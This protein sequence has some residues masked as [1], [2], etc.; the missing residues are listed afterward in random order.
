MLSAFNLLTGAFLC[1]WSVWAKSCLEPLLVNLNSLHII[2]S[3]KKINQKKY[4]NNDH[5]ILT[6]YRTCLP[7]YR[8]LFRLFRGLLVNHVNRK[9]V[10]ALGTFSLPIIR[11]CRKIYSR[12]MCVCDGVCVC[13]CVMV[14]VWWCGVCVCVWWCVCV[15]DGVSVWWCVCVCVM[16]FVNVCLCT[17]IEPNT[18]QCSGSGSVGSL[19]GMFLGILDLHPD[20]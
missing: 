19:S 17:N 14:C 9:E 12:I 5:S 7:V 15:F 4:G 18:S 20:P 11:C 8:S 6:S 16:V 3:Q 1:Y 10:V 13:L 2:L